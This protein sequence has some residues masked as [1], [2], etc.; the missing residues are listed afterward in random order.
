M[1]FEEFK[2]KYG[3]PDKKPDN[4]I[5][6][7]EQKNVRIGEPHKSFLDN[8]NN[9]IAKAKTEYNILPESEKKQ[10][11]EQAKKWIKFFKKEFMLIPTLLKVKPGIT[12]FLYLMDLTDRFTKEFPAVSEQEFL[13]ILKA[14]K[15]RILKSLEEQ[16]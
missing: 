1:K 8:W 15:Y 14:Y 13:Q 2:D 11:E 12:D 4:S 7:S 6:K 16:K 10:A 9:Y 5:E 3:T